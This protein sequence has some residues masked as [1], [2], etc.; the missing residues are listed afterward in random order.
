[1]K[2]FEPGCCYTRRQINQ[3]VGGNLQSYLPIANGRVVC[4]C[5]RLDL[6]P[7]APCVVLVGN[8]KN[9]MMTGRLL[10][11]Q[12]GSIP[13]FLRRAK[14]RWEYQGNFAVARS[15]QARE[16]VAVHTRKSG[17]DNLTRV[18]YMQRA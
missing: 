11:G 10:S 9:V 16:E 6:N 18:I 8:R 17:R 14:H 1:M 15:T 4:A 3:E 2:G 5:L 7:E 13:M 12:G